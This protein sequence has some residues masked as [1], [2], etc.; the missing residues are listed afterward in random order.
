MV[1]VVSVAAAFITSAIADQHYR[2]ETKMFDE[3]FALNK[4]GRLE[5]DV[6]D[7][8]VY[9]KKA[10]GESR[11][12]V[13]VGGSDKERAIEY[14]EE[15]FD[16]SAE[17]DGNTLRI[18][19]EDPSHHSW[20][21]WEHYKNI[22]MRV[23]VEVPAEIDAD[24]RSADGDVDIE[25]LSGEFRLRTADGDVKAPRLSG[26]SI[27]IKTADGDIDLGE[28]ESSGEIK[29]NTAD[30]DLTAD[31][32]SADRVSLSSADGDV[33]VDHIKARRVTL[34]TADGNIEVGAEGGQLSARCADGDLSIRLRGEMDVDL[35]TVDGDVELTVPGRM[36]ADLEL[37]GEDVHVSGD[38]RVEGRI[39][40]RRVVGSINDG[41][42][43][44][45]VKTHDGRISVRTA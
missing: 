39:S 24:I 31:S 40:D 20:R 42:H 29:I 36:G 34:A 37:Y 33:E 5:V 21:F 3:T 44:I 35:T 9:V 30:G 10:S 8:D 17:L 2:N 11:V 22:D 18:E 16:F 25:E 13:F 45:K 15:H 7:M 27:E 43:K 23:V 32:F 26:P 19:S 12:Q 6:E 4:G 38:I 28:V 41:G 14:Y 1:A